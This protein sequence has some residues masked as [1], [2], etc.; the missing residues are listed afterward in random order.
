MRCGTLEVYLV[1]GEEVED[2]S[3]VT[4]D[5]IENDA[6]YIKLVVNKDSKNKVDGKDVPIPHFGVI[7]GWKDWHAFVEKISNKIDF[8]VKPYIRFKDEIGEQAT[9]FFLDPD[10]NAIE[11]KAFKDDSYIFKYQE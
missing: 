1:Q 7:L 10:N 4:D 9:M 5:M 3:D 6:R 11:F 8:I 2:I